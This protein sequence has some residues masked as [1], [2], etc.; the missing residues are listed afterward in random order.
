MDNI[1]ILN[2]HD[3]SCSLCVVLKSNDDFSM[4]CSVQISEPFMIPKLSSPY[5][6]NNDRIVDISLLGEVSN[7]IKKDY[8][9][10]Q[11]QLKSQLMSTKPS[12]YNDDVERD[13]FDLKKRIQ[14]IAKNISEVNIEIESDYEYTV[15]ENNLKEICKLKKNLYEFKNEYVSEARKINGRIKYNI[16]EL[17]NKYKRQLLSLDLEVFESLFK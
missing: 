17:D 11:N 14:K 1:K 10:A 9:N 13:K 7:K 16:R 5:K 2:N 12:D 8:E 4:V 15:F 3:G 6:V